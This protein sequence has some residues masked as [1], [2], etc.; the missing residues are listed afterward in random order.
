MARILVIEDETIVRENLVELL[1]TEGYE[2]LA[3]A[4][5][6]EGLELARTQA[7]DLIL[8]DILMPE[9]SGHEVLEQLTRDPVTAMIPFIFLTARAEREDMRLGMSLGAD[10][11]IT[12]PFTHAD[13]LQAITTRLEKRR[14]LIGQYE[15]KLD[16]LRQQMARML[17]HELRTPLSLIM[18]YSSLL[19]ESSLALEPADLRAIAG[20]ILEAS[21]R[22]QRLIQRFLLYTELELA[23]RD[24]ERLARLR[25]LHVGATAGLMAET[26]RRRARAANREADLRL[27]LTETPLAMGDVYL[28]SLI[29][30]LTENAFKFS[31]PGTPVVV[32]SSS[33]DGQIVITVADR[34]RGMTSQQMADLGPSESLDRERYQQQGQGLGLGLALVRRIVAL[35]GGEWSITSAP[36]E[37][38]TVTVRLPL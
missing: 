32:R 22:L 8:C 34:G 11:Y 17:P 7:P 16:D 3:A 26:A 23:V 15:A 29:E 21:Q 6:R 5:G 13:V 4:D 18:G 27:E 30:E 35:Y 25:D 37:G 33:E 10:D 28:V 2:V 1:E 31:A 12:K 14:R 19:L 38:T 9:M 24:P 20:S 36:G